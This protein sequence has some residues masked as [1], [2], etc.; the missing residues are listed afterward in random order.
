MRSCHTYPHVQLTGKAYFVGKV[1]KMLCQ[2][3]S[4][5]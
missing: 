5:K 3:I 2:A 4:G 1:I